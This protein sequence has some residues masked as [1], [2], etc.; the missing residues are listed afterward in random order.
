MFYIHYAVQQLKSFA[1]REAA[2]SDLARLAMY[3]IP[4]IP[5]IY[6]FIPR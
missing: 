2:N 5:G 6:I 3:S 4:V 1:H